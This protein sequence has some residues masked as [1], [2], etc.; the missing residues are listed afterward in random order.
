MKESYICSDIYLECVKVVKMSKMLTKV[1]KCVNN[2][3]DNDR[4]ADLRW[5]TCPGGQSK[6]CCDDDDRMFGHPPKMRAGEKQ[7]PH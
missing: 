4:N 1:E 5:T 3:F 7:V 2:I 6:A